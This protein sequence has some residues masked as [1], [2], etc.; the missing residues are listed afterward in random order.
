MGT[1]P[2]IAANQVSSILADI[3]PILNDESLYER[4]LARS[5]LGNFKVSIGSTNA[6]ESEFLVEDEASTSSAST[7]TDMEVETVEEE[8]EH[9]LDNLFVIV[10]KGEVDLDEI[11]V[12]AAHAGKPKGID[13][14]HL[15]KIWR[16]DLKTAKRT[17]DITSQN[18]K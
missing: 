3:S 13:A 6:T 8:D 10:T 17:L 7:D 5:N 1:Y 2:P 15:S 4:L 14:E 16:I 9:I 18:S 12:S 11:M